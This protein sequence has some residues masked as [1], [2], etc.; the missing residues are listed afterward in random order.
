MFAARGGFLYQEATV[1]SGGWDISTAALLVSKS[2]LPETQPSGVFFKPDGTVMFVVGQNQ[3]RVSQ[4]SLSTAWDISTATQTT[5]FFISQDTGPL[6]LYFKPDGTIMYIVGNQLDNILQY[7]LSTPWDI[8]VV[9][10]NTSFSVTS[11]DLI[12]T[13]MSFDDTGTKM[14]FTGA[15]ND[16]I[17]QYSLS[18]A[19]LISTATFLQDKSIGAQDTSPEGMFIKPDGTYLYIVGS[20][21]DKVYEYVFGT[22]WDISTLTYTTKNFSLN[23]PDSQPRGLFFRSDGTRMFVAGDGTNTIIAYSVGP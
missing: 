23:P 3:D 20:T 10:F 13:A 14:Y 12:P 9:T 21:G 8:G 16:K 22:A 4:W 15:T 5:T 11:R 2:V 18:T 1:P 6:D 19:W 7:T 17:Y